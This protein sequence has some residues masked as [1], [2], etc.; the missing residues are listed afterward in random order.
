MKWPITLM[1]IVAIGVGYKSYFVN[2]PIES[3]SPVQTFLYLPVLTSLCWHIDNVCNLFDEV[4][5]PPLPLGFVFFGLML[6]SS[7]P[8]TSC[9]ASL[10][11]NV[12]LYSIVQFKPVFYGI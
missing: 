8:F 3:E 5:S 4:P 9:S 7:F 6:L 2:K 11:S 1:K 10:S 12:V